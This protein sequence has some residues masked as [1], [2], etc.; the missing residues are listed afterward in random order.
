MS[1]RPR[2]IPIPETKNAVIVREEACELQGGALTT[3]TRCRVVFDITEIPS[4]TVEI[5][6][7]NPDQRTQESV[8]IRFI[9]SGFEL[10]NGLLDE[11]PLQRR[12]SGYPFRYRVRS[13]DPIVVRNSRRIKSLE[14]L[15]YNMDR[16]SFGG[17]PTRGKDVLELIA[18][19]YSLTV[20]P[21]PSEYA[22][23]LPAISTPWHRAT[24]LLTMT[25]DGD[26]E[27]GA[28]A[29]TLLFDVRQFLSF[30]WGRYIGIALARGSDECGEEAFAYWGMIPPEPFV[31][32]SQQGHWFLPGN[33]EVLQEILPGYMRRCGDIRWKDATEWALYWWLSA[34]HPGQRSEVAIL[35]SVAGLQTIA[36]NL[37]KE[38]G[39][40]P[41]F[42][43]NVGGRGRGGRGSPPARNIRAALLMM[44]M[45][46]AIEGQLD[47]L[48]SVAANFGWD[49]PEAVTEIRNALAHPARQGGEHTAAYEASQLA[50][51]YLE[52]ALLYLFDF[53]GKCANRTI[54]QKPFQARETVPWAR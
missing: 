43:P 15:V 44:K 5:P 35:A 53:H 22:S 24:N 7:L 16:F 54:F 31:P 30:A 23:S 38:C 49:G 46:T 28:E 20:R 47:E 48:R 42:L 52:M 8:S 39:I 29:E 19:R 27:T 9:D 41:A 10:R 25:I 4:A 12:P 40:T 51:W 34:N 3:R 33:A 45:P 11:I 18:D 32:S 13:S 37:Q 17:L 21:I 6:D 1:E 50:M 36:S 2:L 14:A 26:G